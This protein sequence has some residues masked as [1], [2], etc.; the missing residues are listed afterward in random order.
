MP[1]AVFYILV[2]RPMAHKATPVS[3]RRPDI[4]AR[5]RVFVR[6]CHYHRRCLVNIL[7]RH[8]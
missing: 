2:G 8:A 7:P 1:I 3:G 6:S 5:A 4:P